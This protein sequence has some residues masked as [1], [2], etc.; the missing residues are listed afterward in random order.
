MKKKV[1]Y[2]L[3]TDSLLLG[4]KNHGNKVFDGANGVKVDYDEAKDHVVITHNGETAQIKHYAALVWGEDK[5]PA[6][7]EPIRKPGR[8]KAQASTPM[9][10]VHEGVGHGK[11]NENM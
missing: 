10:H 6:P 3:L 7:V 8:P 2:V 5:T 9:Q 1:V 4:K 11:T